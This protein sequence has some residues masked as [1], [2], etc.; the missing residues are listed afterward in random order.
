MVV[1][2]VLVAIVAVPPISASQ[3]IDRNPTDVHLAT[4]SR[5]EALVTYRAEGTLKHVL[6]WGGLNALAPT[7]SH[8][9]IGFELDYAGGYGKYH[10]DYWAT[11]AG[12]CRSYT[13]PPLAWLVTACTAADGS[14]WALQ[15]WRRGLPNFGVAA[16]PAEAPWELRLSH[17]TGGLAVLDIQTDWAYRRYD[18]LF[19]TLT[20]AGHPVF[21]FASTSTGGP[22][23]SFGR[24]IYLDTFDSAYGAGWKRENSFLAH[25]RTGAFCYGFFPHGGG[26]SPSGDGQRYR[27][28]VIGPGVTPDV[29]W[30]GASPGP[31]NETRDA[32]ANDQIRALG[33][34]L[35]KAN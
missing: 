9:Q 26:I 29:I 5:G 1:P 4:N 27:A 16:T 11:F 12:G 19:G 32:E 10:S 8:A 15:A 23:D 22:L 31:Y 6:A 35:C 24:N 14:F 30:E 28:T 3:L 13:G 2:T 34:R 25:A 18:H 21:G 20:Y 17:W 33:D 7:R